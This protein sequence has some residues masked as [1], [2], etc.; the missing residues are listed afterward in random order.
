MLGLYQISKQGPQALVTHPTIYNVA[1][2][3]HP[4]TAP[5]WAQLTGAVNRVRLR[6]DAGNEMIGEKFYEIVFYWRKL[7]ATAS[8]NLSVGIR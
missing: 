4:P 8:G 5:T 6:A 1:K 2:V 3:E 7:T